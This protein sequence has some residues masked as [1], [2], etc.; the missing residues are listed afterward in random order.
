[1]PCHISSVL[2]S[3]FPRAKVN[4]MEVYYILFPQLMAEEIITDIG[5]VSC[6]LTHPVNIIIFS[7]AFNFNPS[8]I[9]G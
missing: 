7:G 6:N 5:H 4:N 8:E 2:F 9:H 3:T 1:M